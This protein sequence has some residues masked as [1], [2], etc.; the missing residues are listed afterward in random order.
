[1]SLLCYS[2]NKVT[3]KILFDQNSIMINYNYKVNDDFRDHIIIRVTRE[4]HK[5]DMQYYSYHTDFVVTA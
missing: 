2:K 5:S 4:G 3:F 1:M